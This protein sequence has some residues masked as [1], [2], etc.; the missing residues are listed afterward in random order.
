MDT[1]TAPNVIFGN[2]VLSAKWFNPEYLLNQ[3]IVYFHQIVDSFNNTG[4]QFTTVY[5]IVSLFLFGLI[6]FFLVIICYCIIRL[7]EIRKKEHEHLHHELE[8]YAHHH[9][10]KEKK[11]REA[12]IISKN[13][14][15]LK[16]LHYLFSQHESEWKLSVIEADSMLDEL[17]S[18]L[19]FNGQS[20]G[21][22]LKAASQSNF[23]SLS[24]AWEVHT[25]RNRI[26][27][28]GMNFELT[29]REA[30]RVIA[31]YEQIFREFGYI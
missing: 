21:D 3:A 10:E 8:E 7:F 15:W 14:H 2:S 5:N 18:Q 23:R 30:K 31:L 12:D 26:A 13:P 9:A 19:G 4:I 27:H 17:M 22:K 16:T 24:S 25:I 29:Q 6:T 11:M 1:T 28:E 20:L